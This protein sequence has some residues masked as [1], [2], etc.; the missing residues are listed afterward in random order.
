MENIVNRSERLFKVK[1]SDV[2][3]NEVITVDYDDLIG[4]ASRLMI[5]NHVHSL[6]V[7]KMGKPAYMISTYDLIKIS[8]ED[9]FNQGNADMLR[10]TVEELVKGQKLVSITSDSQ[11]VAALKIFVEYS[12]HSIPVIDDEKVQGIITLMGLAQWYQKT[13][14]E[15]NR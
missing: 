13:H 7:M 3:T 1:V 4:K 6:L 2:M 9:T 11:L 10:T 8:Y 12:I 15:M 14:E 5:E